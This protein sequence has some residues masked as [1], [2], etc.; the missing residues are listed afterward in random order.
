MRSSDLLILYSG[1]QTSE[2]LPGSVHYRPGTRVFFPGLKLTSTIF[3]RE[4]TTLLEKTMS[5]IQCKVLFDGDF[6]FHMDD[7]NDCEA[8]H[9]LDILQS[10]GLCQHI[11]ESTHKKGH[12]LDLIITRDIES[13]A[14]KI[15]IIYGLPSDH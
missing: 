3:F 5:T 15:S 14:S 4:F 7:E 13:F 12:T 10:A 1:I 2:F 6:N 9:M 8:R 11:M